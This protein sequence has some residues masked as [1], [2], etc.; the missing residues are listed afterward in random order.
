[1]VATM[2]VLVAVGVIAVDAITW[3]SLR[4]YL[5]GQV[6]AQLTTASGQVAR[7]VLHN[8]ERGV[9]IAAGI[10]ARVSPGIFAE[11]IDS[12]GKVVVAKPSVSRVRND[13][14]PRLPVPLPT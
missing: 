13:P 12:S 9:P 2:I 6:D 8:G 7:Y 1:M 14:A 3:N 11:L 10:R 5:Y 4:S